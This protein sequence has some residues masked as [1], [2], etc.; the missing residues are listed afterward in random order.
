MKESYGEGLA[1]HTGSE[2]CGD[3]R[4]GV[5]EALTGERAGWVIN[6]ERGILRDADALGAGGRQHS[7]HRYRMHVR[8]HL[9]WEP[10]DPASIRSRSCF[11]THREV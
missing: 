6:R 7:V 10:G 9:A 4:K 11:G 1:I 8:K 2:S 3:V 5:A